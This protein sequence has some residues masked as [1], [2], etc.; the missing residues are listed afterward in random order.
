MGD[1]FLLKV[2]DNSSSS[3]F[4]VGAPQPEYNYLVKIVNPKK[5]SEFEVLTLKPKHNFFRLENLKEQVRL[6]CKEKV[7]SH[8]LHRTRTLGMT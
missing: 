3:N 7:P 4:N 6:D 2:I 1:I 5:K 8:W